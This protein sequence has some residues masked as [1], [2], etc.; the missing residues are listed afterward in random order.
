VIAGG[1]ALPNRR[2]SLG[3]VVFPDSHAVPAIVTL[4]GR[5]DDEVP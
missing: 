4:V 5:E 3:G 1:L 2:A